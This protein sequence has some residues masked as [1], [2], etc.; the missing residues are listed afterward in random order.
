M[1]QF[2][3]RTLSLPEQVVGNLQG[4]LCLHSNISAETLLVQQLLL[5]AVYTATNILR[6]SDVR[7]VFSS[8]NELLLQCLH[9]GAGQSSAAQKAVSDCLLTEHKRRRIHH[10]TLD[11]GQPSYAPTSSHTRF[12]P[13]A[14]H[15]M[16]TSLSGTSGSARAASA[17][18]FETLQIASTP[19]T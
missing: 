4:F 2:A 14:D 9:Q 16:T 18:S 3:S 17:N 12:I 10:H 8:M 11:G 19:N 5:F 13:G 7:P 15:F 1:R 6:H